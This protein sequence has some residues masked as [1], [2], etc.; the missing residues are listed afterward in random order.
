MIGPFAPQDR[1]DAEGRPLVLEPVGLD[2]ASV[3]AKAEALPS[4]RGVSVRSCTDAG[5]TRRDNVHRATVVPFT[6]TDRE[7]L[8][9]PRSG[10]AKNGCFHGAPTGRMPHR[11]RMPSTP[12]SVAAPD[13]LARSS[14]LDL[15]SWPPKAGQLASNVARCPAG[16]PRT[17]T[18]SGPSRALRTLIADR[19]FEVQRARPAAAGARGATFP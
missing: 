1:E 15:H 11:K 7:T 2:E 8:L 14:I 10:G 5:V 17:W 12:R 4:R 6:A 9:G 13:A 19:I 16:S 18:C 3:E